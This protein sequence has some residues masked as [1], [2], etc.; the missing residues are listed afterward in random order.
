M[1]SD[2]FAN[3]GRHHSRLGKVVADP[4]HQVRA[5]PGLGIERRLDLHDCARPSIDELGDQ[6]GCANVHHGPE[7]FGRLEGTARRDRQGSGPT[8]GRSRE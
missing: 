6:R 8:T 2:G 4:A 5:E 7:S 1:R 3:Q